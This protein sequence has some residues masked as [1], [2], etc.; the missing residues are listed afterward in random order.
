MVHVTLPAGQVSRPVWHHTV[1]EIWYVLEGRGQ[2]WR[3]PPSVPADSE[4]PV[5]VAPGDALVI[6]TGW[7]FQFAAAEDASLKFLCYTSPPWPGPE[8]ALAAEHGGLG[9]P[10][11]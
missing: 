8:E 6:P 10:T 5:S 9:P 11:V 2:V 3:C 4:S 1:E 7:R